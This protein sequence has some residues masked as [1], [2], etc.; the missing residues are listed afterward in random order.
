MASRISDLSLYLLVLSLAGGGALAAPPA[1]A[2]TARP[3]VEERQDA[4]L[5]ELAACESGNHPNP[6]RS[7]YLGRYQF[8]AATVIAYVRERDGRTIS[9]ADD[10]QA[11]ALAR[12]VVFE[13]RGWTH[14]PA[15]S[16]KLRMPAK[17]V[18]IA[19]APR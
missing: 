12:F 15:C 17:I 14:W 5:G 2:Q 6:D 7:G 13:R 10:A 11:G 4:L 8:S 3:G 1:A 18:E 16:R 19:A 9:A